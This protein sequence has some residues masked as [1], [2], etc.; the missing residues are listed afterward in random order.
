MTPIEHQ[1]RR[2]ELKRQVIPLVREEILEDQLKLAL[3]VLQ[4]KIERQM[5][6]DFD[7]ELSRKLDA[8]AVLLEDR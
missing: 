8:L 1:K 4:A 5:N 6:D 3:L 2:I 7:P